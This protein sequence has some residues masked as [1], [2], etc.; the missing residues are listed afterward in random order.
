VIVVLDVGAALDERHKYAVFMSS[1]SVGTA[2]KKTFKS[3]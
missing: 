3:A 1:E 2:A